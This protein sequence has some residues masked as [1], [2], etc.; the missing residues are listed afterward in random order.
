M[1]SRDRCKVQ[2]VD[3]KFLSHLSEMHPTSALH[4]LCTKLD[5]PSPNLTSSF[6]CGP[7][8]GRMYIWKVGNNLSLYSVSLYLMSV[9]L[10]LCLSHFLS[11]SLSLFSV[12][13]SLLLSLY[14]S[15]TLCLLNVCLPVYSLSVCLYVCLSHIG[16]SIWK[17]GCS[18]IETV[19][20]RWDLKFPLF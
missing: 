1:F 5:W 15:L 7:P 18:Y 14:L 16:L 17:V 19:L 8:M 12:S 10:S 13:F 11:L 6:E 3:R 20:Q 2:I 9:C 4:E